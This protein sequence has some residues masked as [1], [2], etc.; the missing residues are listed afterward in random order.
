MNPKF[1]TWNMFTWG[2][3]S[4]LLPRGSGLY[5][6]VSAEGV[7]LYLGSSVD[8]RNR[9]RKHEMTK[10]LDTMNGVKVYWKGVYRTS[11]IAEEEKAIWEMRPT[12][13]SITRSEEEKLKHYDR[14]PGT[15][16][17]LTLTAAEDEVFG[18]L[19]KKY[20]ELLGKSTNATIMR[21][22]IRNLAMKVGISQDGISLL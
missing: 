3:S 9:V 5:C 1:E 6:F 15:V 12:L 2:E 13:N 21:I 11:L 16:I 20:E 22:A 7:A 19:K 18:E 4:S 14:A 8:I 10:H 17:A